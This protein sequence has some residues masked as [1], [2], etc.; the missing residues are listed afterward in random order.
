M[1]QLIILAGL[2]NIF[3]SIVNKDTFIECDSLPE[4]KVGNDQ[5]QLLTVIADDKIKTPI[6]PTR[7]KFAF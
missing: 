5:Q 3:H 6:E 4:Y 1:R 2:G 7:V